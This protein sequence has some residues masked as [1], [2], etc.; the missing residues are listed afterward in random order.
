AVAMPVIGGMENW[1]GPVIGSILLGTI[2]QLASVTISSAVN[3]LIVGALLCLF[4]IIAPRGLSDVLN[5][6]AEGPF[7]PPL[8]RV[9]F[10][11]RWA[12]AGAVILA[13]FYWLVP[14]GASAVIAPWQNI[15][16]SLLFFI[17]LVAVQLPFA[18]QRLRDIGR[19]GWF[20]LLLFV[21]LVNLVLLL[22]LLFLP[23]RRGGAPSLL[24]G[25]HPWQED[26]TGG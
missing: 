15:T 8:G 24:A 25:A 11:I 26:G 3:L 13:L 22:A 2:Q 21:P 18:S 10:L 7:A 17:V 9:Q 14:G 19:T 23:S 12:A 6:P 20:A 16:L 5:G 4:V 1:I